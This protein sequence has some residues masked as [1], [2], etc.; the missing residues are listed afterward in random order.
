MAPLLTKT[1]LD[2]MRCGYPD[3][4]HDHAVMHFSPICHP[5][6]PLR[7]CYNKRAGAV[8]ITCAA[9]YAE[10]ARIAPEEHGACQ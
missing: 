4:K 3:C 6:K 5:G 1:E 2:A 10:V 9:C 7:A 8:I